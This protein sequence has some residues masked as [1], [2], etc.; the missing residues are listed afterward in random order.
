MRARVSGGRLLTRRLPSQLEAA[1]RQALGRGRPRHPPG[2][3]VLPAGFAAGAALDFSGVLVSPPA[4]DP[5]GSIVPASHGRSSRPPSRNG[6]SRLTGE[7]PLGAESR[8]TLRNWPWLC[9]RTA[10]IPDHGNVGFRPRRK[11]GTRLNQ[12]RF[13]WPNSHSPERELCWPTSSCRTTSSALGASTPKYSAAGW[14]SPE[15]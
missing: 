1:G 2:T 11:R 15:M 6:R 12:W 4:T 5:A 3:A 13:N 7:R 9:S 8:G 10:E 14:S